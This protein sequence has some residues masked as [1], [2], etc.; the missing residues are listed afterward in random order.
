MR[1]PRI[2]D[3]DRVRRGVQFPAQA[4]R[5][6]DHEQVAFAARH[7]L[8][9]Q[10]QVIVKGKVERPPIGRI[11]GHEQVRRYAG[12]RIDDQDVVALAIA[13]IAAEGDLAPRARPDGGGILRMPI[14]QHPGGR[15]AGVLVV[16]LIAPIAL[17]V[18]QE[19]ERIANRVRRIG[20]PRDRITPKGQLA[21]RAAFLL[22]Q[23]HLLA[24]AE[25]A[26]HQDRAL[27]RKPERTRRSRLQIIR[28]AG[29]FA[30]RGR[31]NPV[32]RHGGPDRPHLGA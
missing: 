24:V 19:G 7:R 32:E 3:R 21:P 30:R 23:V 13:R 5:E 20:R 2:L 12:L 17:K 22:D 11:A 29:G 25:A 6:V 10:Q 4:A 26:T 28:Q 31:R 18:L 15:L 1:E 16:K 9:D 14:A 27:R 8:Q